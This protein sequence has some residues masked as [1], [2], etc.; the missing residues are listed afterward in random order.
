MTDFTYWINDYPLGSKTSRRGMWLL[1]ATEYAPG[2]SPRRAVVEI[3][4]IHYQ[5]PMWGDPMSAATVAMRIRLRGTDPDDLRMLWDTLVG[6]LGTSQWGYTTLRR[7]RNGIFQLAEAQLLSSESPEFRAATDTLDVVVVFNI[8]GGCWRSET[9]TEE[10]LANGGGISQ[11]AAASTMPVQDILIQAQGPV[12]TLSVV[13]NISNTGIFW[14][15]GTTVV[16]SGQYL[17]ISTSTMQAWIKSGNDWTL[18]GTA[19]NATLTF[20]GRSVLVLG[21]RRSGPSATVTTSVSTT[22]TGGS[23]PVKLRARDAR[24]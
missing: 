18:S 5:V 20:L 12:T 11:I 8:P 13:D 3:P 23:G 7:E 16:P 22:V 1:E 15:G 14:G 19:S 9:E 10:T 21:S 4:N 24:I 6:L 2:L 17:L